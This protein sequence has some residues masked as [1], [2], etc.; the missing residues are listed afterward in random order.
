MLKSYLQKNIGQNLRSR[1]SNNLS[2]TG[3]TTK[4]PASYFST[5]FVATRFTGKIGQ[6]NVNLGDTIFSSKIKVW[7]WF[8]NHHKANHLHCLSSL[9]QAW[10]NSPSVSPNVGG[11]IF[12]CERGLRIEGQKLGRFASK[13]CV[14]I[15]LKKTLKE[16]KMCRENGIVISDY[17]SIIQWQSHKLW[18]PHPTPQYLFPTHDTMGDEIMEFVYHKMQWWC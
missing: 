3:V 4:Y 9:K 10:W 13:M 6:Q 2:S 17:L 5:P 1:P 12:N 16:K 15:A 7:T 11:T 14:I 18:V 8:G